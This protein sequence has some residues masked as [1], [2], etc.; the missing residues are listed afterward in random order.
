MNVNVIVSWLQGM[1]DKGIAIEAAPST[2]LLP[3]WGYFACTLTCSTD[4]CGSYA[5]VLHAQ[6]SSHYALP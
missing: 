1:G 4:M 2:G 3:P 6:V 5:D